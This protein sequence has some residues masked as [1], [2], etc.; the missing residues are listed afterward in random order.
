[1]TRGHFV[2]LQD[3]SASH[4]VVYSFWSA[5]KKVVTGPDEKIEIEMQQ[6]WGR[7]LKALD[8]TNHSY[9]FKLSQWKSF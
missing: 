3:P 9:L 5:A 8:L 2:V 4:I 7:T 6:E 1:M